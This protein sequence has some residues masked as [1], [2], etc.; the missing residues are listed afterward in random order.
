MNNDFSS[1]PL[2]R[3]TDEWSFSQRK[4]ISGSDHVYFDCVYLSD[5]A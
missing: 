5:Y 4:V 1:L 3:L 2:F